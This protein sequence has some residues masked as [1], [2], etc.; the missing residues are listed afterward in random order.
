MDWLDLL[1]VQ[2]TFNISLDCLSD[3]IKNCAENHVSLQK[4]LGVI[5][6]AVFQAIVFCLV[7]MKLFSIFIIEN[8]QQYIIKI[9]NGLI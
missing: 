8:N 1:A 2:G 5:R 3:K 7:Q 9:E 4:F 6:E